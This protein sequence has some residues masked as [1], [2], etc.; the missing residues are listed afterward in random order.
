MNH[1]QEEC[2]KRINDKKPCVT[3]K[4]QLYWPKVN[5]TNDNPNTM[6]KN[7]NPSAIESVFH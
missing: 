3:S 5:S 6:Q 4:G 2:R 1:T 7:S